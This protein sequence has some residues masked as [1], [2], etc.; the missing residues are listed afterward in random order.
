[1]NYSP[2][3]Y[4]GGKNCIFDFVSKLID[5]NKLYG[6]IYA[7]PY[8]GGSGLA[9]RLLFEEYV[10]N[11]LIND[12]DRSIYAFWKT[13]LNDTELFCEWI[14][15]VEINIK[16]WTEMKEIQNNYSKSTRF[17]LAKST[18]FLNRTN[19][20]GIIKGGV[21]GGIKQNGN[22]KIDARFNK[23]RLIE[24]IKKIARYKNRIKVSN[25]DGVVFINNNKKQL[26][27]AFVYLDPPYYEKGSKL[28]MNAYKRDDHI[29]LSQTLHNFNVKWMLSYDN[30]TFIRSLYD[31]YK[32]LV[33]NLSQ[34][35]SNRMGEELL[36]FPNNMAY[37]K[38]AKKLKI[39]QQIFN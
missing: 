31:N 6:Q 17:D 25:L 23:I 33:Y 30:Q 16:T 9:L 1:M 13:I 20:S 32:C 28:Y 24:K 4:P 38:S 34:N 11:I 35:T 7:E 8:A 29:K 18:F 26:T 39:S 27:D 15:N 36:I 5:E 12:L 21:I 14:Y 2:L 19:I 10:D 37:K 22:Y 3:R